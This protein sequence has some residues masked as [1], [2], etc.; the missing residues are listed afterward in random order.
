MSNSFPTFASDMTVNA[1]SYTVGAAYLTGFAS[2]D[3]SVT[4]N[5][6][7]VNMSELL[8]VANQFATPG[9]FGSFDQTTFESD[10]VTAVTA[11]LQLVA[12]ATGQTLA[13][14]K[15]NVGITIYRDIS[16]TDSSG[17][18]G[19]HTDTVSYS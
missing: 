3:S 11:C 2:S 12:D 10:L 7:G 5:I 9:S 16:Y 6:T 1:I 15:S 17:F 8:A 13:W 19:T 18:Q 4:S 14:V